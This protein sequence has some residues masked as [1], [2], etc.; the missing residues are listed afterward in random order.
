MA[1]ALLS[2]KIINE[3][4]SV[5][6]SLKIHSPHPKDP[7]PKGIDQPSLTGDLTAAR[8]DLTQKFGCGNV[9]EAIGAE[10]PSTGGDGRP[11]VSPG[12]R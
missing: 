2:E 10:A 6:T 3:S 4:G 11:R 7:K 5:G 9:I 1:Q 12:A 8:K